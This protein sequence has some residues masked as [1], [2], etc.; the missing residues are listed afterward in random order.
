MCITCLR[1]P[2]ARAQCLP[3]WLQIQVANVLSRE[4]GQLDSR[5]P[6]QGRVGACV[7][8]NVQQLMAKTPT[9][10]RHTYIRIGSQEGSVHLLS[11]GLGHAYGEVILVPLTSQ[12]LLQFG[13]EVR[14]EHQ[15][16][17]R[18]QV[19]P[20]SEAAMRVSAV[21]RAHALQPV[22]V[23]GKGGTGAQQ[24][25]VLQKEVKDSVDL[26]KSPPEDSITS[27]VGF[28]QDLRIHRGQ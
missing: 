26:I 6:K 23:F 25:V 8:K 10:P 21:V 11:E 16:K 15:E 22:E 4:M 28:S 1:S 13:P 2:L 27:R 12:Y 5:Q 14:E 24:E 17:Q 20:A 7:A 19:S 9:A 3:R 18:A